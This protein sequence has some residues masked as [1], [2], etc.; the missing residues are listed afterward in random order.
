MPSI[1]TVVLSFLLA[2]LGVHAGI[3][4]RELPTPADLV[5]SKAYLS[6]RM[7]CSSVSYFPLI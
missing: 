5:D 1:Q 4:R 3:I 2:S 7:R 6:S